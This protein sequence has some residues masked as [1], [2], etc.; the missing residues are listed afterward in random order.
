MK[1]PGDNPNQTRFR[2]VLVIGAFIVAWLLA[3]LVLLIS[4]PPALRSMRVLGNKESPLQQYY[5]YSSNPNGEFAPL[6]SLDQGTWQ[7]HDSTLEGNEMPLDAVGET[8]FCVRVEFSPQGLRDR[9]YSERPADDIIRIAGIGDSFAFGQ[10]APLDRTLFKQMEAALGAG[11]EVINAAAV[12][13][14]TH[15]E[16][17]IL[18]RIVSGLNPQRA[19]VV[20]TLNDIGLNAKLTAQQDYINDLMNIRDRYVQEHEA[21]AWYSG[22]SRLLRL[23]GSRLE[24]RSITRNTVQ[25]Y[26]DSYDREINGPNLN[27]LQANLRR[28]AEMPDCR[29]A[30]VIFPLLVDLESGYPFREV[31][32]TVARMASNA[33]LPVL[34]LEPVFRG[35]RTRELQ[36]HPADQHPN[37]KAHAIAARAIVEWLRKDVPGF[38]EE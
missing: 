35:R 32:E 17:A 34:D 28:M 2:L 9:I 27:Q 21:R 8:P 6:P 12:D 15:D 25:W 26:R 1:Q 10:G 7:L 5:C 36:V 31:H 33:G 18:Q 14:N 13:K 29:V 23:V 37:G 30:F 3:E 16:V 24:M 20:F 11:F 4:Q 22:H 19:I 38:L